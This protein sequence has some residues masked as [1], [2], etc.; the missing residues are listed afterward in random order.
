M[1]PSQV[2]WISRYAGGRLIL[3]VT[4]YDGERGLLTRSN[5]S[6]IHS[7]EKRN[8]STRAGSTNG[9]QVVEDVLGVDADVVLDEALAAQALEQGVGVLVGGQAHQPAERGGSDRS[10]SRATAP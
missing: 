9:R 5:C 3:V 2:R 6:R 8:R 7:R 1:P 10:G 4:V